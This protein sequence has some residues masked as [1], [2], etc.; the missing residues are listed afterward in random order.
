MGLKKTQERCFICDEL[1]GRAGIA[2]D[3][4]YLINTKTKNDE[5]PFCEGCCNECLESGSHME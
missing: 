1:T 4:I 2:D 3:S 5:G